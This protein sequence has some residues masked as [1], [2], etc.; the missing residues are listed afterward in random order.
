M[1]ELKIYPT[2][3]DIK[4]PSFA[5]EQA[6]CFDV[7]YQA[8]GKDSYSGYNRDNAPIVRT[9]N[10]D[11][12]IVICPGDRI[13]V[14]TGLILDIPKGFSVRLHPRSGLST[15]KGIILGN[16]EGVIDSDY[17]DELAVVLT[18]VS[19]V[20]MIINDGDRVAQAEMVPVLDYK[21]SLTETKPGQKTNRVGGLGSTGISDEKKSEAPQ[22]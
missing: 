2:H 21:I 17:F 14:P 7:A 1:I 6:A 8:A 9:M 13:L 5:T 4:L 3:P 18:N 19:E 11:S 10:R 15:K 12:Q 16:T 22:K 20:N